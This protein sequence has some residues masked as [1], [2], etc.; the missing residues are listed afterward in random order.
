NDPCHHT[1]MNRGPY[2]ETINLPTAL[3]ISSD[4][5]FYQLGNA[6]YGQSR[7]GRQNFQAWLHNLGFGVPPKGFDLLT[8]SGLVP[9]KLWKA[10]NPCFQPG[11]PNTCGYRLSPNQ[12]AIDQI[13]EPGDDINMAIGQGYLLVSPLQEAVA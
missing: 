9:D 3:T 12:A 5:F 11:D 7:N 6:F 2:N 1:C 10:R 13:W 4:T 8:T